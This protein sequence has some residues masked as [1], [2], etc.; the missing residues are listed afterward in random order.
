M[1]HR[2]GDAERRALVM[3]SD[4]ELLEAVLRLAAAAGCELQRAPDLGQARRG[5]PSAPLVLLDAAAVDRC[6]RAG[7]ARRGAGRGRC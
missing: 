4:P 3:I 5:W 2:T 1:P 6:A 7:L